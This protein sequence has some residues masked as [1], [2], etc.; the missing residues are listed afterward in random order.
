[1]PRKKA[2]LS[3]IAC[4]MNVWMTI[5]R[6]WFYAIRLSVLW[7][8]RLCKP[9]KPA[10]TM[11][12]NS[13]QRS[14]CSDAPYADLCFVEEVICRSIS[15]QPSLALRAKTGGARRDRTDDLKLAK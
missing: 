2:S 9:A 7:I 10:F 3:C 5:I 15:R 13:M 4:A 12:E 6:E 8:N 1:M 14:E 11:S